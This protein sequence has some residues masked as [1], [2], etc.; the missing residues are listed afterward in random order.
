MPKKQSS[1]HNGPVAAAAAAAADSRF[2]GFE[3]NPRYRLPS[4]SRTKTKLDKRFSRMLKDDDFIASAK[5][6]RYGRKLKADNKKKALQNMYV[7]DEDEDEEG[8]QDVEV[9]KDDVVERELQKADAKYDPAR[10]G[11]FS[12]S[13]SESDSD[14]EG[15]DDDDA[16]EEE[17]GAQVAPSAS[18]SRLRDEQNDVETGEVTRRIA[19]VNL[20]WDHIKSADLM[21][22]FSSFAPKGGRIEKV[23][24]YPSEFGKERMQREEVEGPPREIFKKDAM[25]SDDSSGSDSEA[26]SEDEEEDEKIKQDI[27]KEGDDQDFD[28]DALRSYQ[29]DRLRY[30]YAVMVCSD[31]ATAQKIYQ[32][33]DGTEYQ[34][35]SNFIDLRFIPDDVTFDEEPRDECDSLTSDYKPTEFVTDALQHSKVKLTWDMHPDEVA[36]RENIKRAFGA[37]RAELE[38]NNDLRAYLASDSEDDNDPEE[39][40][41]EA[42]IEEAD[43]QPKLTKKELKAQKLREALGLGAEPMAKASKSAPVGDMQVT[44][45]AALMDDESANQKNKKDPEAE[46]TTIEKYMRKERERKAKKK[47]K[48]LAKRN[49]GEASDDDDDDDEH[50]ANG[51]AAEDL[52]FDDP[53]FTTD[54]PSKP[55]KTSERKADRL[56]RREAREAEAAASAAQRAQLEKVMAA[57]R[58]EP[59]GATAAAAH[60]DHFDMETIARAEKLKSQKGKKGKSKKSKKDLAVAEGQAGD[61]QDGFSMDVGDARFAAVFDRHEFA[62]DPSNPKFKATPGMKTLL[63][64]GR[65]KRKN[66]VAGEGED[67]DDVPAP[68]GADQK[69]SK[70]QKTSSSGKKM[71]DDINSLVESV[72]RKARGKG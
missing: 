50:S 67:G 65:K 14:D 23:S 49:G 64:E 2:S 53:F 61:L 72:R 31:R 66:H 56:K 41:E 62:I 54:E 27:L 42:E 44:F 47:E 24:I 68:G 11:G 60:L 51:D 46:E 25:G 37:S 40:E 5:V 19:I 45:S 71:N 9:E 18:M 34:T 16:D 30:Y 6:D 58:G 12:S 10:G 39:V 43:N 17:G 69:K 35:S 33:T 13:D 1:K 38:D 26:D 48:A 32:S 57:D 59:G 55:S 21:A 52:G 22:L 63:E 36:R 28:S 20:D 8:H 29:L 7:E 4:K 70:K 3:N 15:D